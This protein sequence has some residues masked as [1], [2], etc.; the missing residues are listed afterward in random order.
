MTFDIYDLWK[1]LGNG[2]ICSKQITDAMKIWFTV[3]TRHVFKKS[4]NICHHAILPVSSNDMHHRP[5]YFS[6]FKIWFMIIFCEFFFTIITVNFRRNYFNSWPKQ[7]VIISF[8]NACLRKWIE[9]SMAISNSGLK[10]VSR[11]T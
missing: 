2:L 11:K 8:C 3:G 7:R 1:C 9:F 5:S 6:N 4:S 10:R